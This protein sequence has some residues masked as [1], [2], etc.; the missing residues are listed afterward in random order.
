[1]D[2]IYHASATGARP[3]YSCLDGMY[4]WKVWE[5]VE[6]ELLT[7]LTL[8][9]GKDA[10]QLSYVDCYRQ[11][12]D[13]Y[14]PT[15]FMATHGLRVDL[16]RL[17]V[18]KKRALE[19]IAATQEELDQITG[20]RLNPLSPKSCQQYFYI[21]KGITPYTNEGKITT[22]DT[23]LSRIARRGYREATLCQQIR[24]LNKLH[25]TYL[26][27]NVDK[28]DRIR[29]SWNLRGTKEGRLSSSKTIFG[30][31]L[32]FQNLDPLFKSFIVAEEDHLFIEIDKTR[33]EWVITAYL[34]GDARMID[35]VERGLDV[36]IY[37]ASLIT[38]APMELLEHEAEV[39]GNHTDPD[40]IYQLRQEYCKELIARAKFL[41]RSMSGRQAGKKGNHA[42]NYREGHRKFSLINEIPEAEGLIIVEGYRSGYCNLKLWWEATETEVRQ[43]RILDNCFGRVRRFLGEINDD[44]FRSAI[45]FRPQSTNVDLVNRGMIK[46]YNDDTFYMRPLRLGAQVHDSILTQYPIA[47]PWG[48]WEEMAQAISR[49]AEHLN[50]ELEYGGRKFRIGSEVKVGINWGVYDPDPNS[51]S[52]NPGGMKKIP[53]TDISTMARALEEDYSGRLKCIAA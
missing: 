36:H 33:S 34:S 45:A 27:V 4:T 5:D 38:G 52:H 35:V 48:T 53:L 51:P 19:R 40:L 30:I 37:T 46:T 13:L 12:M 32:N 43:T 11:T 24:G 26:D 49:M 16:D 28:D 7:P 18:E 15:I 25:S 50:P 9:Y 31:G 10:R 3:L 1:M 21:E 6:P 39:I 8:G 2:E 20:G 29:C 14:G 42:L 17:E 23:A 44:L 22:D 47:G 41:P